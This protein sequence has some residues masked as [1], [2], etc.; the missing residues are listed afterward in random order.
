MRLVGIEERKQDQHQSESDP[1]HP[2]VGGEGP[3]TLGGKL[4]KALEQAARGAIH[5][6]AT[7]IPSSPVGRKTRVRIRM[8]NTTTLAHCKPPDQ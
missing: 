8:L 7:R 5:R 4:G 1:G 3:E 6:S 2:G